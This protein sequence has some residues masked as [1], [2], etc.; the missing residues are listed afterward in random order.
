MEFII[1]VAVGATLG[2]VSAIS[3]VVGATL[4]YKTKQK[5]A[6]LKEK[7]AIIEKQVKP[8]NEPVHTPSSDAGYEQV[9]QPTN[10]YH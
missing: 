6:E 4:L 7:L 1:V 9:K 2:S 5:L 3:G 10:Y 8:N